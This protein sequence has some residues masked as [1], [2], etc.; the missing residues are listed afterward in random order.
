M[1]AAARMQPVISSVDPGK[2]QPSG[3]LTALPAKYATVIAASKS[4]RPARGAP[5]EARIGGHATP[6]AP[7][8]SP[9]T[10]KSPSGVP[11]RA[12]PRSPE[13]AVAAGSI[14]GALSVLARR[15]T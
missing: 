6:I 1:A 13:V 5:K 7:A 8:G 12:H 4:P 9:S 15:Y 11:V 2:R 3:P 14:I 10:T